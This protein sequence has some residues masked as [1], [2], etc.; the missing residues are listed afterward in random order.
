[1]GDD[2]KDL[3]HSLFRNLVDAAAHPTFTDKGVDQKSYPDLSKTTVVII[4]MA[5][6]V[7]WAAATAQTPQE[8]YDRI[9]NK[10]L[11][12]PKSGANVSFIVW[13]FDLTRLD[14]RDV[15]LSKREGARLSRRPPGARGS[16]SQTHIQGLLS[17]CDDRDALLC[18]M[19]LYF[20]NCVPLRRGLT[21]IMSGIAHIIKARPERGLQNLPLPFPSGEGLHGMPLILRTCS[22]DATKNVLVL[23]SEAI[24]TE[25]TYPIP[26]DDP[27][28]W[29][30]GMRDACSQIKQWLLIFMYRA[31]AG[32]ARVVVPGAEIGARF[33]IITESAR[34]LLDICILIFS[35]SRMDQELQPLRIPGDIFVAATGFLGLSV[36]DSSRT[37]AETPVV[38]LCYFN[39]LT[40][41]NYFITIHDRPYNMDDPQ[42]EISSFARAFGCSALEMLKIMLLCRKTE[43][44]P[45]KNF[46]A[47][48]HR[49]ATTAWDLFRTTVALSSNP[50]S[51]TP[52]FVVGARKSMAEPCVFTVNY[53]PFHALMVK[54]ATETADKKR[55][56]P[57]TQDSRAR[58]PQEATAM[59]G[60][61]A[62]ARD[63]SPVLRAHA[64]RISLWMALTHNGHCESWTYPGATATL[65]DFPIYGYE[66]QALNPGGPVLCVPISESKDDVRMAYR[67]PLHG[68]AVS[69]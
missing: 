2:E 30:V 69:P 18:D 54:L 12:D 47:V 66:M 26:G 21:L 62:D 42:C 28:D 38:G 22:S 27:A 23:P 10:A 43:F 65:L 44:Y 52:A 7:E 9:E 19:A 1:M 11:N 29:T 68:V 48:G 39:V 5:D 36:H 24:R 67:V 59:W 31:S 61:K 60:S 55:A 51:Q 13:V 46:L 50:A 34:T 56:Q 58:P 8:F 49:N 63:I 4:D 64:A 15:H 41:V 53:Q 40:L 20:I 57:D 6:T 33:V 25:P 16:S 17:N 32:S 35:Y 45:L 37:A 14:M 3:V